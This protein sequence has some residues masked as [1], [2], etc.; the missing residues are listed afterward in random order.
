MPP[1]S[2]RSS[3]SA[4]VP[5]IG[6]YRPD[7]SPNL[8]LTVVARPQGFTLIELMMVVAI[9]GVLSVLAIPSFNNY[10]QRARTTEATQFLGAIKLRQEAFRSEF[11]QYCNIADFHPDGVP[12]ADARPWNPAFS[13]N[14]TPV[15]CDWEALGARPD[16]SVRF[17]YRTMAGPPGNAPAQLGFT[18]NDNDFWFWSQARGD[19]DQDGVLVTFDSFSNAAQIRCD[20]DRGWD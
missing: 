13:A 10:V 11:G 4:P 19:L 7:P 18:G 20:S 6:L 17:Q 8:L 16:T 3:P 5:K 2:P 15:N 1:C 14:A 12:G 9:V